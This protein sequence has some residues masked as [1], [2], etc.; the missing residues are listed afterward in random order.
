MCMYTYICMCITVCGHNVYC[1][2]CRFT[3]W[4]CYQ[5]LCLC[6]CVYACVLCVF[7][8]QCGCVCVYVF[9]RLCV[10]LCVCVS[11]CLNGVVKKAKALSSS[12]LKEI[13]RMCLSQLHTFLHR[14]A[15]HSNVCF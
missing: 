13:Q 7:V 15:S 4:L 10:C 2:E 5:M 14:A 6:V 11:Q 1:F 3:V 9:F 8:F 12:L